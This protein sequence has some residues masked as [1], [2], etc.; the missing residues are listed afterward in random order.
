MRKREERE[1]ERKREEREPCYGVTVNCEVTSVQCDIKT[2]DY[3]IHSFKIGLQSYF[4][5]IFVKN[6][7]NQCN[8][9]FQNLI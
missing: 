4:V 5:D 2:L 1:R 8:K 7:C 9:Q 6:E 3:I